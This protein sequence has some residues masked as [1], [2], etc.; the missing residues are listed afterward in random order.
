L[1]AGIG[2]LDFAAL[3]QRCRDEGLL[4][5][6]MAAATDADL[7]SFIEREVGHGHA[8]AHYSVFALPVPVHLFSAMERPT[9][10]SRRSVSLGW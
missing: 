5:A 1:E 2:Q 4:Y 6:Q 8:L 7:L 10:L 3:L 9:E